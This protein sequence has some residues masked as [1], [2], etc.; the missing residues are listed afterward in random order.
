LSLLVHVVGVHVVVIVLVALIICA[1]SLTLNHCIF[2]NLFLVPC[3]LCPVPCALFI[4]FL[5]L[6]FVGLFR[7]VWVLG[8]HARHVVVPYSWWFDPQPHR[9]QS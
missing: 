1:W 6:S 8:N 2:E 5:A 4:L 3:A 7:H 9:Q